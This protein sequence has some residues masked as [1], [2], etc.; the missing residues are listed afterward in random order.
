MFSTPDS[1]SK[2]FTQKNFFH[3]PSERIQKFT[4]PIR[5]SFILKKANSPNA[6]N[7]FQNAELVNAITTPKAW[8]WNC[9][10]D[11]F[12]TFDSV[13]CFE[14]RIYLAPSMFYLFHLFSSFFLFCFFFFSNNTISACVSLGLGYNFC[15]QI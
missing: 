4:R 12:R 6:N 15:K 10:S 7:I 11:V 5:S 1:F 2:Q 3:S 14:S 9:Y 8:K 13:N